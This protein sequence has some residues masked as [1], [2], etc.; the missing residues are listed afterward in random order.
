MLIDAAG[1]FAKSELLPLDRACDRTESPITDVLPK[2]SEM[3]FLNLTIP[4]D[5]NGLG[6]PY[7][8]YAAILHELA[9]W[10]PSTAVTVSVH[11]LT[12]SIINKRMSEPLRSE[13]LS[14]WGD[15]EN[16]A[17]FALTEAGAGSDAGAA[18]TT[19]VEADGGFRV[20]GEKMW[21]TNGLRA[22]WF[23]TLVRLKD[24]PPDKDLCA[25]MIDGNSSGVE[26]TPIHG[27]MGIRGSETAVL[28]LE[29]VFVPA[30]HLVGD[31]GGGLNVMLAGLSEGRIAIG[32]QGTG[33]AEACLS[34]MT[35]YARQRTQF[36]RPIGKFQAVANMI[37]DSATELAASKALIW[38]AAAAVDNGKPDPSF[39]SMAKVYATES[40]NRIAYRA[41]QVHGGTGYVNES[42]V[43]QLFRDARV[44]TIYEGTSEI[45][46][47]VIARQLAKD[48]VQKN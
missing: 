20:T 4:E 7:R 31:R 34:E 19:A 37:A 25:L 24:A 40:A 23:L 41:V 48:G 9:C 45:L 17:A 46:R 22:R 10:S 29:N 36:D 33:I 16:F 38:R 15:V 26:R 44:T 12:G 6:C 11:L 3:G 8:V 5:L 35:S 28:H 42:R 30:S 21:I 1:E 47:L 14:H 27:K 43:E 18:A 13:W 32:A 39:S 2:L